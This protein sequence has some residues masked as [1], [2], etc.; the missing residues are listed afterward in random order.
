MN[1]PGFMTEKWNFKKNVKSKP[2]TDEQKKASV[3][4]VVK[5]LHDARNKVGKK[6]TKESKKT[7]RNENN[8]IFERYIKHLFKM[9]APGDGM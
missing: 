1:K 2:K 4:K 5:Q 9:Q 7:P 8:L 6:P 3:N